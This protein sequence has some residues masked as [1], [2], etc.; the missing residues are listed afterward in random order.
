MKIH[1]IYFVFQGFQII[2]SPTNT[3][4]MESGLLTR[5]GISAMGVSLT[6]RKAVLLTA[7]V[8]IICIDGC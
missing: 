2:L 1:T 7:L 4:K 6:K 3:C 5:E 8:V